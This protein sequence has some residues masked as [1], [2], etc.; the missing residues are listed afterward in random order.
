ML[1]D[2]CLLV[3]ELVFAIKP[4]H[5]L[6][7]IGKTRE[8][9]LKYDYPNAILCLCTMLLYVIKFYIQGQVGVIVM[10]ASVCFFIVLLVI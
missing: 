7:R 9:R 10:G 1:L 5:N 4:T 3:A 6:V 8:V 2:C